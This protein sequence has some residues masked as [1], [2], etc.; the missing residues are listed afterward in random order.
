MHSASLGVRAERRVTVVPATVTL[1]LFA[2]ATSV[3]RA[4]LVRMQGEPVAPRNDTAAIFDAYGPG[5]TG[6]RA[7]DLIAG[8][9]DSLGG[10]PFRSVQPP[11][12]ASGLL[13]EA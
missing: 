5:G 4:A 11:S 9:D 12:N 1:L 10:R 8:C 7:A 6:G 2:S 3:L 13:R